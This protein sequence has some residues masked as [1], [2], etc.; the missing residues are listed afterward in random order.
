VF[1]YQVLGSRP[2]QQTVVGSA[3]LHRKTLEGTEHSLCRFKT[4]VTLSSYYLEKDTGSKEIFTFSEDQKRAV[5]YMALLPLSP[6]F[7]QCCHI[8][9]VGVRELKV[10]KVW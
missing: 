2:A 1:P 6:R 4:L 3:I 7:S 10:T 5:Y 8:G 9:I